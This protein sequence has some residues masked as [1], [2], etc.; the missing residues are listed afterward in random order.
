MNKVSVA[1][2]L[3]LKNR[4]VNRLAK[5]TQD[6]AQNNSCIEEQKGRVDVAKLLELREKLT[7]AVVD[8][9]VK[10]Q[11]ANVKIQG[12]LVLLSERKGDIVFFSAL[13][14]FDGVQRHN[15][16]NT[17]VKHVAHLQKVDVDNKVKQLEAEVDTLQDEIDAYNARTKIDVP[18]ETLDLAS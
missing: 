4:L 17:E 3:K 6:I 18:Q 9:R 15:Y 8:V 14:T 11:A 16:Q 13:N 7:Q 1:K 5:T 12:K 2:A 10:V